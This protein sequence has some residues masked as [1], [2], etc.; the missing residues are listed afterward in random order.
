MVAT[1]NTPPRARQALTKPYRYR[2]TT[3]AAAQTKP[4]V[5]VEPNAGPL[6]EDPRIQILRRTGR[7][8]GGD[9][10]RARPSVPEFLAVFGP[11]FA[12]RSVPP[13]RRSWPRATLELGPVWSD[14]YP[15]VLAALASIRA[16]TNSAVPTTRDRQA[17]TH[18][19]RPTTSAGVRFVYYA[20]DLLH[21]DGR[22][23]S[24]AA[25][26]AQGF[27]NGRSWLNQLLQRKTAFSR[28]PPV[29][30]VDVEGRLRVEGGQSL[31]DQ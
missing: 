18:P 15:G 17:C 16:K 25:A 23:A 21:L 28:F 27:Q 12:R 11:Q 5:T 7:Q 30:G 31:C 29:H 2:T 13:A 22:D 20:F 26:R 3:K 8:E 24:P 6:R 14:R 10:S 9:L 19:R 1:R 4:T